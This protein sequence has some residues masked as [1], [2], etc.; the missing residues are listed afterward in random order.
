MPDIT[1]DGKTR[2]AWVP[3][4]SNINAPTTTELNAGM[5]LQSTLTADGLVGLRP[6]TADVDTSALDSTFSTTVN[7]R[8]SFSGTM[9]R[10]KKQSGT[11]TI[12]DTLVR[13]AAGYV[14]VRRSVAASTAWASAQ[15][16][17]VYPALC[18]EV[19]RVD[20]EPNTVERYEIPLKITS[21]PALRAAV[22]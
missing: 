21:S 9:L 15:K 20:P 22:A 19:A 3:S 7:G 18:G 2:V 14:V 11:D 8:T 1:A 4:I 17:E 12:F 5:L 10:L 16:V 13:D 6:E